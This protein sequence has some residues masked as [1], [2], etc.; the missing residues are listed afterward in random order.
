MKYFKFVGGKKMVIDVTVKKEIMIKGGWTPLIEDDPIETVSKAA[1]DV[2]SKAAEISEK[3][4][5]K[6]RGRKPKET[7]TDN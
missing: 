1:S 5:T 3:P 4:A 7:K 2:A 6:R